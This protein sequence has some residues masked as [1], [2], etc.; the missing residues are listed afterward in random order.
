MK[1]GSNARC[2]ATLSSV[3]EVFPNTDGVNSQSKTAEVINDRHSFLPRDA[4]TAANVT[5]LG[6]YAGNNL[7]KV[8]SLRRHVI[9]KRHTSS[10]TTHVGK[11]V[12]GAID[13]QLAIGPAGTVFREANEEAEAKRG[14][15]IATL[16]EAIIS[17][18]RNAEGNVRESSSWIRPK[19]AAQQIDGVPVKLEQICLDPARRR[20][21]AI[22]SLHGQSTGQRYDRFF[23]SAALGDLH[24][25]SLKPGPFFERIMA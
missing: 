6:S 21:R 1:V 19:F 25:P 18:K 3:S 13:F 10:R 9:I 12:K 4:L 22:W 24:R 8:A 16:M 5:C 17:Q 14:Q 23:H 7:P 15:I 20:H 11:S 2:R